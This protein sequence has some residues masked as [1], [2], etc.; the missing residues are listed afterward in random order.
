V[1]YEHAKALQ[2]VNVPSHDPVNGP[3]RMRFESY[4]ETNEI[5]RVTV[6]QG[7]LSLERE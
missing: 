6:Q 7:I 1:F 4:L 3:M 5:P 2:G